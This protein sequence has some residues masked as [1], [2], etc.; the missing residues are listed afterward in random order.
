MVAEI[1]AQLVAAGGRRSQRAQSQRGRRP[2]QLPCVDVR[3]ALYGSDLHHPHDDG[4]G[5]LVGTGGFVD[6]GGLVGT[7]GFVDVG[8]LVCFGGFGGLVGGSGRDADHRLVGHWIHQHLTA[9]PV[10]VDGVDAALHVINHPQA[11]SGEAGHSQFPCCR[12]Y[13]LLIGMPGGAH[14]YPHSS[15]RCIRVF[16]FTVI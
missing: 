9:D 16:V 14:I 12:E 6:A 13:A 5:G 11:A 15:V 4:T 8:G 10:H 3:H 1:A 7:G 2:F